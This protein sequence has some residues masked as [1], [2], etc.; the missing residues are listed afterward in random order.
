LAGCCLRYPS[1]RLHPRVNQIPVSKCG[2]KMSSKTPVRDRV[3]S[4]SQRQGKP[5]SLC[6]I[7]PERVSEARSQESNILSTAAVELLGL[8]PQ[9]T[10]DRLKQGHGKTQ[11]KTIHRS[12]EKNRNVHQYT[13]RN[14]AGSPGFGVARKLPYQ[15]GS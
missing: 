3:A 11:K 10:Q 14:D 13:T 1:T 7:L 12:R 15:K 9:Q 8:R 5:F 6:H 4:A 2:R